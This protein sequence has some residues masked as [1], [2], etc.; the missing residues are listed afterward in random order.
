MLLGNAGTSKVSQLQV[1]RG[2][3]VL[4]TGHTGFKGSWLTEW[5]VKL[6]ADVIGYSNEVP[7]QPSHFEALGLAKRIQDHRGDIRDLDS[8]QK[9]FTTTKPDVVFHLAAQP[10]VRASYDDPKLTFDT[11][12]GG[13]VNFLE[14]VRHTNSVRAAVIITTD[15]VYENNEHGRPFL[16]NE[17]L[18]GHDPYSASKAGTEI[19]FSSY[20]RSFFGPK[21]HAKLVSA[22]AGNVI[23]GGDWAADRIVADCARAWSRGETVKI[24]NPDSVRP[25]QHVLEPVAA[26]L[27]MGQ[28]LLEKPEGV[29]GE[30]FNI[31]PTEALTKRTIELVE[32]LEN[33]WSGAKHL[34]ERAASDGK[35]EA[36]VLRLNCDKARERLHWEPILNFQECA[37]WTA[38]WYR[39]YYA[40][41]KSAQKKTAEQIAAFEKRFAAK[42]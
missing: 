28:R 5:L 21:S 34:V 11:N 38:E 24:R 42:K 36:G 14:A 8:L 6:G 18:G 30:A 23:G 22:R 16:E 1:Y 10:I 12:V 32:E 35:K 19:V 25:W 26:Y 3:K 2:K 40:D 9:L 39:D 37:A 13:T 41:P 29:Q 15:K 27:L 20:S 17:S 4:V 31:G 33:S 7:T